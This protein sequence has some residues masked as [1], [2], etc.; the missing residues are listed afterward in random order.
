MRKIAFQIFTFV[1]FFAIPSLQCLCLLYF[2]KYLYL[3]IFGE[4]KFIYFLTYIILRGNSKPIYLL[5]MDLSVVFVVQISGNVKI[6]KIPNADFQI[7]D[8][9]NKASIMAII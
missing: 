1:G 7:N 4:I 6:Q 9:L 5:Y 3:L 2:F 8:T